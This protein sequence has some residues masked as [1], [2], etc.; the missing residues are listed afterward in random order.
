MCN[1]NTVINNTMNYNK[2]ITVNFSENTTE[3][4]LNTSSLTGEHKV[5]IES[6]NWNVTVVGMICN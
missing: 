2:E 5:V 4:T 3:Y 1:K 6:S